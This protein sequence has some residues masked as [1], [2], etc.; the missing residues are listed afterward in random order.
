[1]YNDKTGKYDGIVLGLS[2]QAGI[3]PMWSIPTSR[4]TFRKLTLDEDADGRPSRPSRPT[5]Q[6]YRNPG[7]AAN[8][9]RPGTTEAAVGSFRWH[10]IADLPQQDFFITTLDRPHGTQ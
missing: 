9:C 1:M 4:W 6:G 10:D 5:H 7:G 8:R 3:G 2:H